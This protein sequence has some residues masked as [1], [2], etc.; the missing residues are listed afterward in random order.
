MTSGEE[1]I[2]VVGVGGGWQSEVRVATKT[3]P[4]PGF[5]GRLEPGGVEGICDPDWDFA[6]GVVA[7]REVDVVDRFEMPG[8]A[9]WVE[10]GE[11]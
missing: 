3:G 4:G 2:S 11:K 1:G 9:A 5:G 7:E 8:V 6:G 10:K